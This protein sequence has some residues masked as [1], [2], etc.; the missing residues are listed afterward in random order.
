MM[1]NICN[2]EFQRYKSISIALHNIDGSFN[3]V[4]AW[5]KRNATKFPLLATL[6]REYLAIPA[7]SAPSERIWSRASRILSLKRARLKPEVAQQIMFVKENL[8][9]LHK[10]Y[11]TLA[12]KE[13]DD[14]RKF[15]VEYDMNYLPSLKGLSL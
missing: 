12:M 9:I 11:H 13:K 1:R 5:W 10:H 3:N 14:S 2:A 7:T 8:S 6:A 4:L 15:M